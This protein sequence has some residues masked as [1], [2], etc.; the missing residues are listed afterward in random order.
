MN[1]YI[2]YLKLC[3]RQL[4]FNFKFDEFLI[5]KVLQIYLLTTSFVI[6]KFKSANLPISAVKFHL[7]GEI[8]AKLSLNNLLLK[9]TANLN[10]KITLCSRTSILVCGHKNQ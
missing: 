10:V 5:Q 6:F 7:T 3:N 2:V 4:Q 1:E 8:L 9:L